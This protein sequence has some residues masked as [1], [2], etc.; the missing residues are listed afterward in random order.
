MTR[1]LVCYARLG[2]DNWSSSP[3]D[4]CRRIEGA[5]GRNSQLAID[6]WAVMECILI[7]ELN[8]KHEVLRALDEIYIKPSKKLLHKPLSKNEISMRV[9]RFAYEN[10]LDERTVYRRLR[11]ARCLWEDICATVNKKQRTR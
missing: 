7:L 3:F 6:V 2:G 10:N 11:T 1:A 8:Q 5:F 9:L 4:V